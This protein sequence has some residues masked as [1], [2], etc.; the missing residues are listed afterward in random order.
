MNKKVYKLLIVLLVTAI[1]IMSI[2]LFV[3][4][5]PLKAEKTDTK[6][7]ISYIEAHENIDVAQE[8]NTIRAQNESTTKKSKNKKKKTIVDG[9]FRE[10]FKDIVISGD[11]IVKAIEEYG[12]LDSTQVVGKV[13]GSTIYLSETVEEIVKANPK[14]LILHYG[15][16][17]VESNKK[18]A[19]AF[20]ERYSKSIIALKKAL[21][22]TKIFVDSIFP[23]E[24]YAIKNEPYLVNIGYYNEKI[25]AMC[26]D[27]K[28]TYLDFT[29]IWKGYTK[30][31]YDGD[32]IHPKAS[33]YS[34]QYLPYI[35]SEVQN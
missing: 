33:Y 14:Y 32:G 22:N 3:T 1:G 23:V 19:D 17:E 13:G 10:A 28:V 27:L 2:R 20:I 26:T 21:P 15:E 35:Y 6:E 9:N 5:I 29:P 24:D 30:D 25:K 16:N 12:Y 7:G 4:V 34:E 8:E 18:S 31:Y 11:S